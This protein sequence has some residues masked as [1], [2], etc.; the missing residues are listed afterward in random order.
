MRKVLESWHMVVGHETSA[1]VASDTGGRERLDLVVQAGTR[2]F[3][4][5]Y[6]VIDVMASG[7]L[8]LADELGAVAAHRVQEKHMKY[9]GRVE[10][11]VDVRPVALDSFGAAAPETRELLEQSAELGAVRTGGHKGD[12]RQQLLWTL[13]T[14]YFRGLAWKYNAEVARVD[15]RARAFDDAAAVV[16]MGPPYARLR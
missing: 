11:D 9:D 16:G 14:A 4:L 15:T 6:S 12:L 7:K 13:S 3:A 5:D 8:A 1:C 10:A 2:R